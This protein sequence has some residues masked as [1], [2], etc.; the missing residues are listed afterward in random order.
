MLVVHVS[1]GNI[2]DYNWAVSWTFSV[3]SMPSYVAC[4]F[5]GWQGLIFMFS[6]FVVKVTFQL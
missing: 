4:G 6:R 1:A 2:F 3:T 5:D